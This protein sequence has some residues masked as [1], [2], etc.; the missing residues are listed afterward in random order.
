MA[1]IHDDKG[2]RISSSVSEGLLVQLGLTRSAFIP[3]FPF[4]LFNVAL[5]ATSNF[6]ARKSRSQG[7]SKKIFAQSFKEHL[8]QA[9]AL[10]AFNQWIVSCIKMLSF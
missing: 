5:T 9:N 2:T 1:I 8:E 3:S 10:G 4:S 6:I 7:A